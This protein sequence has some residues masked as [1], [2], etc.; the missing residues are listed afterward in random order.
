MSLG[1]TRIWRLRRLGPGVH[2]GSSSRGQSFRYHLCPTRRE[3]CH[4]SRGRTVCDGK[5]PTHSPR[6]QGFLVT[7][8][9]SHHPFPLGYSQDPHGVL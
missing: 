6:P 8:A 4:G 1:V 9:Y 3:Q 2:A 7:S 5:G